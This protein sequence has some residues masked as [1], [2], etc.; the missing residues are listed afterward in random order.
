M[1][2]QDEGMRVG[3]CE[4]LVYHSVKLVLLANGTVTGM[5]L[6][7]MRFL[8]GKAVYPFKFRFVTT[9]FDAHSNI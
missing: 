4:G 8:S 7:A 9:F 2:Q 3:T 1:P 5:R 6:K